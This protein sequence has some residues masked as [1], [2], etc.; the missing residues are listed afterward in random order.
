MKR[1][2]AQLRLVIL[3]GILLGFEDIGNVGSQ[4]GIR[5]RMSVEVQVIMAC[6]E[7]LEAILTLD[8]AWNN[9]TAS[10]E[11][12]G[13]ETSLSLM[14]WIGTALCVLQQVRWFSYILRAKFCP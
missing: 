11:T 5:I 3:G 6:A 8:D 12:T 1:G 2:D 13:D 4:G 7:V 10:G 14:S 9:E